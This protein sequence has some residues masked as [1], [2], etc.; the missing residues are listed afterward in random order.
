MGLF[1]KKTKITPS[2]FAA[3]LCDS[4]Q[5]RTLKF[6]DDTDML[7]EMRIED[8]DKNSIFLEMLI[9]HSFC[10]I[11]I[12]YSSQY[13]NTLKN[14]ILD[15]MHNGLY[16]AF[17]KNCSYSEESIKNLQGYISQKYDEYNKCKDSEN[18][19][20]EMSKSVLTN[21]KEGNEIHGEVEIY[22]MTSYTALI[23]QNLP[24]LYNKYAL[25]VK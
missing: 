23:Y 18:W 12:F 24:E 15:E 2:E 6:L 22:S 16:D 1:S 5:H 19:L 25:V 17:R 13:D 8:I 4:I 10:F 7:N 3:L 9:Y 21:I 11:E 14:G 20:R